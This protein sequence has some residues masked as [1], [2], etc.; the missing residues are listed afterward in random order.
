MTP[1]SI[2]LVVDDDAPV[3]ESLTLLIEKSG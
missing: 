1:K 2:V 3:R